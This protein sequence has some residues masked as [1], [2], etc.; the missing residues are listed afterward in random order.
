M[1][2]AIT[3]RGPE[4]PEPAS[5]PRTARCVARSHA[6]IRDRRRRGTRC[7]SYAFSWGLGIAWLAFVYFG[8]RTL[9]MQ[10]LS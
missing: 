10:L 7:S 4:A 6:A 2:N 5:V 8:P 3:P 9:P 1:S